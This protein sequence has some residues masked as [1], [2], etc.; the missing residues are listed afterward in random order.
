MRNPVL[1]PKKKPTKRETLRE[2][3]QAAWAKLVATPARGSAGRAGRRT[4]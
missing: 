3:L 1:Q 2:E 4:K